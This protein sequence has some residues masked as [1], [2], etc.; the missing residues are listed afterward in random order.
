[1]SFIGIYLYLIGIKNETK[2]EGYG[3]RTHAYAWHCAD[4]GGD[5]GTGRGGTNTCRA[6][7]KTAKKGHAPD[8]DTHN[9]LSSDEWKDTD[10]DERHPLDIYSEGGARKVDSRRPGGLIR[11][12]LIGD[13][14]TSYIC[15]QEKVQAQETTGKTNSQEMQ[16]LKS[17]HDKIDL[18]KADP[19]YGDNIAKKK[20]PKSYDAKNLRRVKLTGYWRMLYTIKGDELRIICFVLDIVD[21]KS[22]DKLFGYRKR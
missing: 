7:K 21:H 5:P 20:I 9:R 13:A 16:L 10:R 11:V 3:K 6:E 12:I 17:I 15:L 18:I 22:Y 8:T 1:M 4:G 14:K 19:F 2:T